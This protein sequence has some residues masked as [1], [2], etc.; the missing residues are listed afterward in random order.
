VGNFLRRTGWVLLAVLFIVTALGFGIY[1][2]IQATHQPDPSTQTAQQ[3][4][5]S[6]QINSVASDKVLPAPEVYTT[7]EKVTSLQKVDLK[8]GSGDKVQ[9]GDCITAKYY[10]TLATNGKVFDENF[11]KPLALQLQIGVGQVIQGWDQGI[12]GMKVG[13]TRRLVIP[14]ALGYGSQAAGSIPANSDLVFVVEVL[15]K[16]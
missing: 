6:C 8:E 13:G 7:Q 10:G 3:K 9:Q 15:S 5:D 2:F 12:V 14:A 16:K 1:G 11:T 4:A